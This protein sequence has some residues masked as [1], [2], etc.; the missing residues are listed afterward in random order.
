MLTTESYTIGDALEELTEQI[1]RLQDVLDGLDPET[2]AYAATESQIDRLTY[3]RNGLVWQRDEEGWGEDAEIELGAMT[4]AE[5]A[6]M[7][8]ESTTDA[9]RKEMRLWFVAASTVDAPYASDDLT[10]TFTALGQCHPAFAQWAEAKANGLGVPGVEGNES[11][12]A[13]D[14]TSSSSSDSPTA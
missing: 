14:S 9:D 7:H 2:D 3:Y 5:E 8:R 1:E 4:A 13:D 6:L 11:A 12:G 10:E